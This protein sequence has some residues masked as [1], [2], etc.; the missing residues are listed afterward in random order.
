M[1]KRDPAAFAV[2]HCDKALVCHGAGA[3][4][5]GFLHKRTLCCCFGSH[6]DDVVV[7]SLVLKSQNLGVLGFGSVNLGMWNLG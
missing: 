2:L 6:F 4:V 7:L 1:R 3:N 5:V